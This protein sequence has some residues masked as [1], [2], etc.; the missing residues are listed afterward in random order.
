MLKQKYV[1]LKGVPD[2]QKKFLNLLQLN[3]KLTGH[4]ETLTLFREYSSK[5]PFNQQINDLT[6]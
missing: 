3:L 5:F 1:T 6:L 4:D 2:S